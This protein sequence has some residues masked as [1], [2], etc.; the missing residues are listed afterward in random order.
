MSKID[1]NLFTWILVIVFAICVFAGFFAMI[2]GFA[3][4]LCKKE[5]VGQS[6]IKVGAN[7][8][9]L[10]FLSILIAAGG[11]LMAI[12]A[13]CIIIWQ[14]IRESRINICPNC[15]EQ[16]AAAVR[17]NLLKSFGFRKAVPCPSCGANIILSKWPW[18]LMIISFCLFL[19]LLCFILLK[20][21]PSNHMLDIIS[22]AAL[23]LLL[24]GGFTLKL[25]S[26]DVH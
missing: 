6:L 24:I 10:A 3:L 8:G 23:V 26:V 20:V 25:E 11:I 15:R 22:Y 17:K 16:I 1:E 14:K 9:V 18:R 21:G 7:C 4:E 2:L 13:G 19:V 12:L 5:K